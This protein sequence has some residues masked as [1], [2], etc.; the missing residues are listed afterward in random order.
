MTRKKI[1]LVEDE[2]ITQLLTRRWLL[3]KGYDVV[4]TGD[5]GAVA[6]LVE[7]ERPDLILLDLGLE[8]AD[9]F[10]GGSFDG[11]TVMDW[12]RRSEE[13]WPPIIVVTGRNDPGLRE[14]VLE[15]GAVAFFQKPVDRPRLL[16][17]IRVALA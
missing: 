15:H 9:P 7:E 8:V 13:H 3:D 1:L 2:R 6:R 17:A 16:T 4:V 12:L 11:L 5:G 14:K 10:S